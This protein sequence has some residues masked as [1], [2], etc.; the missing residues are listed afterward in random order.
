M[1]I[2]LTDHVVCLKDL[3]LVTGSVTIHGEGHVLITHVFLGKSKT[4]AYWDL[5]TDDTISTKERRRKDMHR[6]ALAVGHASLP[7]YRT[8]PRSVQ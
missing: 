6:A 7:S 3:A 2:W 8:R 5:C 4:S 1:D